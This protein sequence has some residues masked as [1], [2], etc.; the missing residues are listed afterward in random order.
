MLWI[1]VKYAGL[2]SVQ[3]EGFSV[4]SNNPYLANFRCPI[5]GDSQKN[6][7][8]KRGYLY[9]KAA[10]LFYKCH[11]CGHGTNFSNLCKSVNSSL[12]RQYHLEKFKEKGHSTEVFSD[13]EAITDFTPKFKKNKTILEDLFY[14]V[15]SNEECKQYL[16]DRAIPE[17]VWPRLYYCDDSKKLEGLHNDYEDKIRGG[18]PRLVIPAFTRTH[19]LTGVTARAIRPSGLRYITIRIDKQQPLVFGLDRIDP[20]DPVYV[21]EGP[22]DSFFVE[23]CIAVGSADLKKLSG[24]IDKSNLIL[25]FDNQPRNREVIKIIEGAINDGF[26][27]IIW[28]D[29]IVFK[30]IN[31]MIVKGTITQSDLQGLLIKSTYSDLSAKLQFNTWRK[32]R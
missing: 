10:G 21:T 22:I 27:V 2:L 15:D 11:N 32:L 23:N 31:E 25:I 1:D 3:L 20:T 19:S 4:K 5:C 8:K 17:K 9:Q 26:K 6:K 18:E 13:R 14:P 16:I 24:F 30:D 12:Q 28:P 7:N 29:S